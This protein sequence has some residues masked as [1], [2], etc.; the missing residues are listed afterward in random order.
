LRALFEATALDPLSFIAIFSSVAARSGNAGQSAYAAANEAMNRAAHAE[1]HRRMGATKVKTINWGP[2]DGGMVT[3]ALKRMFQERGV[4]LLGVQEGEQF[5]VDEV[6][7]SMSE[8]V[9]VVVGALPGPASPLLRV[10]MSRETHS[11]LDSHRIEDV[12]VFPVVGALDL[13]L[14]A[15]RSTRNGGDAVCRNLRVLRGIRLEAFENGGDPLIVHRASNGSFEIVSPAGT[16]HYEA[17]L[18]SE[19]E[20]ERPPLLGAL[21][22]L[23]PSPWQDDEIYGSLLFHGPAFRVIESIEGISADGISATVRGSRAM[24]WKDPYRA[25]D[26]AMLDGGLQLARLWGFHR[27]RRPSLPAGIG[28]VRI[29]QPEDA[30][31]PVRCEVRV[32]STLSSGFVCDISWSTSSGSLALMDNVEMYLL[33]ERD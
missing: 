12:P 17:S 32:R 29:V 13:F 30:A 20:S 1:N 6:L 18:S 31:E 2:W 27:F 8:D 19:Y 3:P 22:G 7:H 33:P 11:F 9:E 15:S 16:R 26:G 25:C 28:A 14:R 21:S 23:S 4:D 5:F 24:R 10:V